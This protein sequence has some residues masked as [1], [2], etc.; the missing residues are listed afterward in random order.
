[1]NGLKLQ[2]IMRVIHD[3]CNGRLNRYYM[4]FWLQL[5]GLN[6]LETVI[7]ELPEEVGF[8]L[9]SDDKKHKHEKHRK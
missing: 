9:T 3:F 6:I 5:H 2:G 1:L 8:E 4:Y 7:E